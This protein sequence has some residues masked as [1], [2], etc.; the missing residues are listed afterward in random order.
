MDGRGPGALVWVEGREGR[1]G[2]SQEG[3]GVEAFMGRAGMRIGCGLFIVT[4]EMRFQNSRAR[5]VGNMEMG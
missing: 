4:R 5:A 3:S 1:I 2:C